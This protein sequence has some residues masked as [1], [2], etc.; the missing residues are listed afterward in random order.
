MSTVVGS[1]VTSLL[2]PNKIQ[3]NIVIFTINIIILPVTYDKLT[4]RSQ[5][6]LATASCIL[7]YDIKHA[8]FY[9]KQINK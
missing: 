3:W 1:L 4:N 7:Y 2:I 9:A 8:E 5:I 6:F